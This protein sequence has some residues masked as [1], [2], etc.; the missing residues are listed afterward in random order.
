MITSP[1]LE[2]IESKRLPIANMI[3]SLQFVRALAAL[4]VLFF[5]AQATVYEKIGYE[6]NFTNIG[7][8]GVDMFFVISGFVIYLIFVKRK[9]SPMGF[10]TKR[11]IRVAPLYW[12][13]TTVTLAL[14]MLVPGAYRSLSFEPAVALNSYF[15]LLS[16][17]S[18]GGIGTL[19][20]VG[21][22]IAFEMYFYLLVVVALHVMPKQPLVFV[23]F[24]II[25]GAYASAFFPDH[26]VPAFAT[27]ALSPLPLE[28]LAGCLIAMAYINGVRLPRIVSIG[29][30]LTGFAVIVYSGMLDCI[31]SDRDPWRV[32]CWGLPA[33]AVVSGLVSLDAQKLIHFPKASLLIGSASYSLYLSHQFVLS[34]VAKVVNAS[35]L[36]TVILVEAVL[37]I[38]MVLAIIMALFSYF[39]FERPI[40]TWLNR[41]IDENRTVKATLVE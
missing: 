20:G 10:F 15:F 28:F 35:H 6:G 23:A 31:A 11:L 2:V 3:N 1:H 21:W 17:N 12:L 26:T 25:A 9:Y 4:M 41:A 38:C 7:A 18:S 37:T 27:V 14:L 40:T 32:L 8:A 16:T 33:A 34:A 36:K 39:F 5:H 29:L 24:V 13:Y 30:I 19:L 22:T